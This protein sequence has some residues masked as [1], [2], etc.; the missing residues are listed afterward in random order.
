M[1]E[2]RPQVISPTSAISIGLAVV[3]MGAVFGAGVLFAQVQSI[4]KMNLPQQLA[5][6]HADLFTIKRQLGIPVSQPTSVSAA[7][8]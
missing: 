5:L 1:N 2:P 4:D 6:I 3:L 7:K 8:R